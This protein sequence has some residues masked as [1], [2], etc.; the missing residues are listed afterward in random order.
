[1]NIIIYRFTK[2]STQ[3]RYKTYTIKPKKGM[4]VLNALFHI[5]DHL[6]PTLSFR[7][8]CRG[9]VC[10]TCAM[11]INKIPRLACRTQIQTLQNSSQTINLAPFPELIQGPTWNQKTSILIEP[12]PNFPV[13]K[14]LIVNL[15]SFFKKYQ[16]IQP[17]LQTLHPPPEKE[18]KMDPKDVQNLENYTNCILCALCYGS[19]PINNENSN[20]LGPAALAKLYR[21]YADTRE[22]NHTKRLYLGNNPDGWWG[23][24]FHTNCKK[25]CP[26]G[27][28]PNIAIGK[29][30]KELRDMNIESS[31]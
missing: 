4:T 12:L 9:A 15:D 27:V 26:K 22:N 19:C 14:D 6:D 18:R 3:P 7:Y 25:V 20:Y 2:N 1:M 28:S 11:L 13:I 17:I 5:Q 23:C 21:F 24:N 29:A 10:G 8:S 30:R 16:K 31:E